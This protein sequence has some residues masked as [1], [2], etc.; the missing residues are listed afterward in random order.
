MIIINRIG[1]CISG[2]FNGQQFGVTFDE[3]K[4]QNMLGLQAQAAAATT[5][6]ELKSIIEQF[7]PLTE[8]SYKE[9]VEAGSPYLVGNK[10]TNKFYLK[11]GGAVSSKPLPKVMVDKITKSIEKGIDITPLV[12]CW[13]RFLRNPNYSDAKAKK[14]ADYINAPFLNTEKA[15]QLQTDK[16]LTREV[17]EALA[18]TTQVGITMEGLLAGYK[19]SAEVLKKHILNEDEEVIQRSR[20]TKKVDADTGLVTYDS[21]E[22][23]EERLFE[24]AIQRNGGDEFFCGS[25]AGHFIRVGQVHFL[26]SWNKVNCDD[27]QSGVKGLHVG[28]LNYIRGY[29]GEGTVTHEVFIDP[30]DIGAIVGL[31]NGS[32]GAIRVRRY[33]VYRSFA[34]AN[35]QIYHSSEYAKITDAEYATMVEEAVKLTQAKQ[36]ELADILGEQ[37]A[38][39]VT[40]AA[41]VSGLASGD[42]T[43]ILGK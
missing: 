35:K 20:Y 28:G 18:T 39:T 2:S 17:A 13:V 34:G 5:V 33:F 26:D 32:D 42:A 7:E 19:V 29:Q 36:D 10:H 21:P 11:Y 41:T 24:P 30:M 25:K 12:K 37:K 8:E 15:N 38:L 6:D 14:F 1:D 4:Y 16:G 3:Q 23:V 40:D 22:Y 31:E 27:R 9:L 43:Q